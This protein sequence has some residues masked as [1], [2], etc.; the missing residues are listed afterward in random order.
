MEVAP[1][2]FVLLLQPCWSDRPCEP[3]T[4]SL[5]PSH[6]LSFGISPTSLSLLFS[7]FLKTNDLFL[8]FFL[9]KNLRILRSMRITLRC[10]ILT[11]KVF[12][13]DE[14][15]GALQEDG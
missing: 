11:L 7:F 3:G 14:T 1:M 2:G 10:Y 5:S 13:S 9:H 8:P 15:E 12:A 4:T 6:T